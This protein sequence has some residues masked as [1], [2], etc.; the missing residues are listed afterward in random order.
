[1]SESIQYKI[2]A[3]LRVGAYNLAKCRH[4]TDRSDAMFAS[5]LGFNDVLEDINLYCAQ[6]VRTNFHLDE[7]DS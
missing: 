2:N 5:A 1:M 4:V 6:T 7:E 3:G